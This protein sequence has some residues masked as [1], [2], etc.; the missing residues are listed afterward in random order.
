MEPSILLG[1]KV[2]GGEYWGE[3][4]GVGLYEEVPSF[5]YVFR[6]TLT[7]LE[8]MAELPQGIHVAEKRWL[9]TKRYLNFENLVFLSA[10]IDVELNDGEGV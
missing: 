9:G 8:A 7:V 4:P 5:S 3:L 6:N 2:I 1:S 10:S